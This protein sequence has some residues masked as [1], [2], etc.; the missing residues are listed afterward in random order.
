[1]SITIPTGQATL[2]PAQRIA[3]AYRGINHW[4][5]PDG[6][7][8]PSRQEARSERH[9]SALAY[10]T[11]YLEGVAE[12]GDVTAEKLAEAVEYALSKVDAPVA[13][14]GLRP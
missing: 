4:Q 5:A 10:L 14:G 7:P 3:A 2:T 12:R 11:G 13:D 8:W 9:K 6:L 1:M